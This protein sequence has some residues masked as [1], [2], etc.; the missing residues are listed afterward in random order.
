M[1]GN[2]AP[3]FNLTLEA[4]DIPAGTF[5]LPQV[6]QDFPRW[7]SGP[8][9]HSESCSPALIMGIFKHLISTWLGPKVLRLLVPITRSSA[10]SRYLWERGRASH[11]WSG[12]SSPAHLSLAHFIPHC[13]LFRSPSDQKHFHCL[14]RTC[15]V[16][17]E[18]RAD[19][20]PHHRSKV[21]FRGAAPPPHFRH[22]RS[23]SELLS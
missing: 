10:M 4:L 5:L 12:F 13:S 23:F 2:T 21:D 3:A 11:G 9:Q 20:V 17:S 7:V 19:P 18:V 14:P 16:H 1:V 15:C 8:R 6:F 22:L